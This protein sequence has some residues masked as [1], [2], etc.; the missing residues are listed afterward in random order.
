MHATCP[1]ILPCFISSNRWHYSERPCD[2]RVSQDDLVGLKSSGSWHRAVWWVAVGF[3]KKLH[4]EA[5]CVLTELSNLNQFY[6][7]PNTTPPPTSMKHSVSCSVPKAQKWLHTTPAGF[8]NHSDSS[9]VAWRLPRVAVFGVPVNR[10]AGR[11]VTSAPHTVL[12]NLQTGGESLAQTQTQ[13]QT[14]LKAVVNYCRPK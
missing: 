3:S 14:A 11:P 4:E 10:H 8:I 5:I 13:T 6:V 2:I 1:P 12:I 7:P 9:S